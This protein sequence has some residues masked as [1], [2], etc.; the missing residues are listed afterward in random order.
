MR[1][2]L[3]RSRSGVSRRQQRPGN[4]PIGDRMRER[5]Y[6]ESRAWEAMCGQETTQRADPTLSTAIVS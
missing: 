2:V 1:F 6:W 4:G 3:R 5:R